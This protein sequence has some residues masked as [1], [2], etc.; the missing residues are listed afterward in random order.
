MT[1][2]IFVAGHRGM[3]GSAI[4]RALAQR[5]A[6]GEAQQ[7]LTA[8]HAGLDLRDRDAVVR[9]FHA[10]RPDQVIIAAGR[11]GGIAANIAQPAEFLHDNLMIATTIIHAAQQAGVDR[12]LNLGSS[13]IYPRDAPQPMPEDV[14]MTGPLDPSNAPYA[15][16]KIAG[17]ALCAAYHSQYGADFRSLMPPNLYGPGDNFHA[18]SSHVIPAL[19]ARMHHARHSAAPAVDI[20]GDGQAR[21]EF[22]F[23]DDLADAALFV[24]DL[25]PQ[26]YWGALGE[27]LAHLNAGSG[28]ETSVATLARALAQVTGYGGEIRFDPAKPSGVARRIVDSRRLERLGWNAKINL[29]NGLIQTYRWFIIHHEMGELRRYC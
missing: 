13:C 17:I 28:E 16:A 27:G 15:L 5:H 9:F 14:L 19:M 23:V 22:M 26:V 8:P 18:T 1:R 3:V 21:R 25:P 2:R 6:A 20:W 12:L 24:L 4:L 29:H 7:I 11:V 10:A